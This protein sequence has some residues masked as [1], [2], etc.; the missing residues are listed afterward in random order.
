VAENIILFPERTEQRDF[1]KDVELEERVLILSALAK[2]EKARPE[3]TSIIKTY[4]W[5]MA[6]YLPLSI[7]E[8]EKFEEFRC[9]H[10]KYL[11]GEGDGCGIQYLTAP[12]RDYIFDAT[13]NKGYGA[14][15]SIAVRCRWT[16]QLINFFDFY[17]K[18]GESSTTIILP[19]TLD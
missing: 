6:D 11:L 7:S 4:P 5:L 14:V 17:I 9:R 18:K 19:R 15:A 2:E 16:N 13:L 8:K 3:L 1:L 12:L 10:P